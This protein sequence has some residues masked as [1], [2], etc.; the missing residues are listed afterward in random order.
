MVTKVK[1]TKKPIKKTIKKSTSKSIKK[2]VNKEGKLSL[3]T[4]TAITGLGALG[5]LGVG[6]LIEKE[7][8]PYLKENY[9]SKSV[10]NI[11]KYDQYKKDYEEL[12]PIFG[13]F[14]FKTYIKDRLFRLRDNYNED[15]ENGVIKNYNLNKKNKKKISR[16]YDYIRSEAFDA[17]RPEVKKFNSIEN[18]TKIN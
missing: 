7:L 1:S 8:F 9:D 10:I 5:T 17:E 16:F 11:Q 3:L 15:K 14:T 2:S 4:K 6:Y 18:L 13:D 12:Y